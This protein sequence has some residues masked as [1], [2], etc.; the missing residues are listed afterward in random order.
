MRSTYSNGRSLRDGGKN[1]SGREERELHC[2]KESV[3]GG[4]CE[5]VG[6]KEKGFFLFSVKK[7]KKRKRKG[8]EHLEG[9]IYEAEV[10]L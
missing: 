4:E 8:S 5:S 7:K 9:F 10:G 1:T 2:F 3:G 6:E